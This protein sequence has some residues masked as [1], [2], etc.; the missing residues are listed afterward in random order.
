MNMIITLVAA[1]DRKRC[2][3]RAGSLPWSYPED[4]KHFRA[5]TDGKTIIMGRRTWESLP[6][7][8]LPNR[9]NIV[10]SHSSRNVPDAEE[11][12]PHFFDLIQHLE[13]K[14]T[15]EVVVIGGGTLYEQAMPFAS[16]MH[17]THIDTVV[18]GGDTFFPDFEN[19]IASTD[20]QNWRQISSRR[21]VSS[22]DLS[23][24]TYERMP[25]LVIPKLF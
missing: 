1:M 21:S 3:G 17:L 16:R 12:W 19:M 25:E 15:K 7:R 2:I 9:R 14:G 24:V 10:L 8:P 18:E 4:L 6:K 23:F 22:P 13:R 20:A 11:C 5:M